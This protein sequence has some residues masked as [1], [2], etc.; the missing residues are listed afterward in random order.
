M[1]A[2]IVLDGD[3][4]TTVVLGFTQA[5]FDELKSGPPAWFEGRLF[6]VDLNVA[7]FAGDTE[8]KLAA[9]MAEQFGGSPKTYA[10]CPSCAAEHGVEYRPMPGEGAPDCKH[11]DNPN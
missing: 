1:R 10:A 2:T 4:K 6:N 9:N 5:E 3:D 8:E 7:V 11:T